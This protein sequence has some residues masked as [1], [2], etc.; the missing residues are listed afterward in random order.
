MKLST[1]TLNFSSLYVSRWRVT[2]EKTIYLV[3]EFRLYNFV[4]GLT[5]KR[6]TRISQQNKFKLNREKQTALEGQEKETEYWFSFSYLSTGPRGPYTPPS[7][8]GYGHEMYG[9]GHTFPPKPRR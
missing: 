9:R 3:F 6:I 1:P 8:G 2:R 5:V 4:S 7:Y